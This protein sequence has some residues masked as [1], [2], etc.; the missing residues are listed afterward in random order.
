[1]KNGKDP[2]TG[3]TEKKL[4]NG[5]TARRDVPVETPRLEKKGDMNKSKSV[6][7][8]GDKHE[9]AKKIPVSAAVTPAMLKNCAL[10]QTMKNNR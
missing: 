2:V 4:A 8:Q 7:R 9:K 10:A 3:T 5:S 6:G 1:M